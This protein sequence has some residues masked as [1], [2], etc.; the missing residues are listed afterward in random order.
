M[1]RSTETPLRRP[2]QV[3]ATNIKRKPSHI[4]RQLQKPI[5]RRRLESSQI[6]YPANSDGIS[7][8]EKSLANPKC[9]I[10]SPYYSYRNRSLYSAYETTNLT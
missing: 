8:A 3:Q 7:T 2:N 5:Q 1:S 10:Q 9:Q 4:H 6:Q